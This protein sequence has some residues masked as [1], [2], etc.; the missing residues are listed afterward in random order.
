MKSKKFT[1]VLTYIKSMPEV[2]SY[3]DIDGPK[4]SVRVLS[5]SGDDLIDDHMVPTPYWIN[6]VLEDYDALIESI[7]AIED[8]IKDRS[9]IVFRINRGAIYGRKSLK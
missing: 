9:D 1:E 8:V 5:I 4:N 2:V 7:S 6:F 3:V